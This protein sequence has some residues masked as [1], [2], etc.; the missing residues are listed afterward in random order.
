M[1]HVFG[2]DLQHHLVNYVTEKDR[3][4]VALQTFMAKMPA[5]NLCQDSDCPDRGFPWFSTVSPN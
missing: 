2:N 5:L 4:T 1:L 3:V